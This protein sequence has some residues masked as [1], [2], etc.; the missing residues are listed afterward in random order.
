MSSLVHAVGDVRKSVQME[1]RGYS[2]HGSATL[3]RS[4]EIVVTFISPHFNVN[5][6]SEA[7]YI[8]RRTDLSI[9]S[10]F[11]HLERSIARQR[12]KC[13]SIQETIQ[14]IAPQFLV[15]PVQG[16]CFQTIG[17]DTTDRT[18]LNQRED[19]SHEH[20]NLLL[21][22]IPLTPQPRQWTPVPRWADRGSALPAR[23]WRLL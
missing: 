3:L 17:S 16:C 9:F 23:D 19:V 4:W 7:D 11:G 13:Y 21:T 20:R 8:G 18:Y 10:T 14:F 22:W 12:A 1:C 2:A 5:Q 15:F 6:F